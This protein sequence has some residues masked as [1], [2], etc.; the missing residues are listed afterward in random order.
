MTTTITATDL[1]EMVK[2]ARDIADKTNVPEPSAVRNL[3][4]F[5]RMTSSL[6][7]L[8]L[9]IDYQGSR[10]SKSKREFFNAAAK[11]TRELARRDIGRARRFLAILVRAAAIKQKTSGSGDRGGNAR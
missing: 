1:D 8:L 3:S 6:E 9:Y 11:A 10:Q 4:E 7:E 5:S 2:R